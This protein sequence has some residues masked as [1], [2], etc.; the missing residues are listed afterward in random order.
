[1]WLA[2]VWWNF[3]KTTLAEHRG[4]FSVLGDRSGFP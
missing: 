4:N 3:R 2:A 1:M